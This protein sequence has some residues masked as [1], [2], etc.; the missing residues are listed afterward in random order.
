M[1][2][3]RG[4]IER[5]GLMVVQNNKTRLFRAGCYSVHTSLRMYID[6][7]RIPPFCQGIDPEDANQVAEYN[8]ISAAHEHE[9]MALA[10]IIRLLLM[11]SRFDAA[12][13]PQ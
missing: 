1:K 8:P 13:A 3:P 2:N 7:A 6:I 12:E 5:H 11:V 4:S 9:T 10:V